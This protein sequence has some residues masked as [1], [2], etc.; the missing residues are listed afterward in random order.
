MLIASV[1][2]SQ[3]A[4]AMHELRTFPG[5]T[6]LHL[7][8]KVYLY[9]LNSKA[10]PDLEDHSSEITTIVEGSKKR[11][12]K[13]LSPEKVSTYLGTVPLVLN[14]NYFSLL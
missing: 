5:N 6:V 1:L 8:V 10:A 12:L 11:T 14:S 7:P 3:R 9:V 13:L 4:R 2:Y